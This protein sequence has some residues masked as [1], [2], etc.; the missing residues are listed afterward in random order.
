MNLQQK[1]RFKNDC[2]TYSTPDCNSFEH[3]AVKEI[4]EGL[5]INIRS[6]TKPIYELGNFWK[7]KEKFIIVQKTRGRDWKKSWVEQF[8]ILTCCFFI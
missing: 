1:C 5:N 7:P 4:R 3:T 2:I 6:Q 8:Q